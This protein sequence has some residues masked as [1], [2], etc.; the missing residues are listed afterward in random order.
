MRQLIAKGTPVNGDTAHLAD[1]QERI[2]LA[3]RRATEI[4]EQAIAL[5]RSLV[6]ERPTPQ[7]SRPSTRC[8]RRSRPANSPGSCTF[9]VERVDYDGPGGTVGMTFHAAGIKTLAQ[10]LPNREVQR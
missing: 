8:G 4:R 5:D 3:E 6:D 7:F 9:L 1:L 2:R 10:E